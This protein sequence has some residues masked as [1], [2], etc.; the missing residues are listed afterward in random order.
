MMAVRKPLGGHGV[1]GGG[2]KECHSG[3]EECGCPAPFQLGTW[4]VWPSHL[5]GRWLG[6]L[7]EY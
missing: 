6:K 7:L 1:E 4:R 2:G 5:L 3:V